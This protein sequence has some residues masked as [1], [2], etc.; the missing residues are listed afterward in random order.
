MNRIWPM[1]MPG[2]NMSLRPSFFSGPGQAEKQPRP[3]DPNFNLYDHLESQTVDPQA[4]S[5]FYNG[6][7]PAEIRTLIFEYA[8]TASSAPD[9]KTFTHDPDVRHNHDPAPPPALPVSGPFRK[10]SY[11][12]TEREFHNADHRQV[13]AGFDWLRP[14][15]T[16]PVTSHYDLLLSCRRVYLEA[17]ALPLQQHEFVFYCI[18]GNDPDKMSFTFD[19]ASFVAARL[20]GPASGPSVLGQP[21]KRQRDLYPKQARLFAQQYWLEDT[22]NYLRGDALWFRGHYDYSSYPYDEG[23]D[24][25]EDVDEDEDSGN[26]EGHIRVGRVD[27]VRGAA[28]GAPNLPSTRQKWYTPLE[29][30]RITLRR[31]DWWDWE[32]NRPLKISPYRRSVPDHAQ[33]LTDMGRTE[34]WKAKR[35]NQQSEGAATSQGEMPTSLTGHRRQRGDA[36]E[37]QEDLF[38]TGSWGLAFREMANLKTLTIDFETSEDKKAEMEKIVEWAQQWRFPL[39]PAPS[40]PPSLGGGGTASQR[41]GQRPQCRYLSAEGRQQ[42]EKMSWR[43]NQ[44]Y[45]S[46]RCVS[47]PGSQRE[48]TEA[49]VVCRERQKL[50][51][52]GLG[53]RL[54]VWSVTWKAVLG[55]E[56]V[57]MGRR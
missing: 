41:G 34:A 31:A 32:R 51:D 55:E 22:Q 38:E 27:S 12:I 4:A 3:Q 1:S 13:R 2:R 45:W 26:E 48:A 28:G 44:A 50:E 17:H 21:P 24:D 29:H 47:C 8:L 40:S 33:M 20:N 49:C 7:I 52:N 14:D 30:L 36:Q 18:R 9:A 15:N 43:G 11:A 42:V 19:P 23:E 5:P 16:R 39:A 6:R 57:Q 56:D 37:D 53:P 25:D 10:T 46:M 54:F 35:Q